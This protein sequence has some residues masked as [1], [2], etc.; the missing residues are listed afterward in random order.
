MSAYLISQVE[1]LDAETWENYRVRAAVVIAQ[2]GGRYLVRGAQA[3]VI[4]ADW[5]A[6]EPPQQS[7]IVAEFPTMAALKSWYASPE[8]AEAFAFR[9][10]AVKRRLIFVAGLDE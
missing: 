9:V 8:Y 6:E 7:V 1:V 5:P 10:L 3:E 4:E 2:F